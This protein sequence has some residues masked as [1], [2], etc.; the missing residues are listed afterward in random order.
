MPRYEYRCRA[1]GETF[2]ATRPMAE[3]SSP[4]TCPNGHDDTVK[5]LTTFSVGNRSGA[6]SALV[7]PPSA[8]AGTAVVAAA[9]GGA[10]AGDSPRGPSGTLWTGID[11]YPS[12]LA[13]LCRQAYVVTLTARGLK[14]HP[15]Q[16]TSVRGALS[17]GQGGSPPK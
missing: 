10:A 6:A 12:I 3:A 14:G 13:A 4:A 2:D 11:G 8:A 17:R 9:A 5:L 7:P 15:H 16:R 1:C